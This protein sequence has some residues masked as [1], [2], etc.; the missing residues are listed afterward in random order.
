L[1]KRNY[2]LN[3]PRKKPAVPIKI[4]F[5]LN[6]LQEDR[7]CMGVMGVLA[8]FWSWLT[9]S[10]M[11]KPGK[12]HPDL[13]PIDVDSLAKEL[14]LTV[15]AKRLGEAGLPAKDS[16][17]L[18][19]PEAAVVQRV[20]KARQDYVDWA[21]LR[22]N[23]LNQDLAR[24]N[25]T[26]EV[27]R[28]GQ[29]DKE[30]ERKASALLAE[31]DSLLHALGETAKKGKEELEEFRKRN[32]L[33][34]EA[35]YPTATGTYLRYGFLLV[36]ICFEGVVNA[37]FFAQGLDTGLIGGFMQAAFLAAA[38]VL[39]AFFI[40][41]YAVRYINHC[42]IELKLL[43]FAASITA[44]T[45]MAAMGLGISHY[46]DSLTAEAVDPARAAL[47]GILAN[48]L[49]LKDFF[50][51]TLFAITSAFGIASLFDGLFSDD[52]YPRYGSISRRTYEVIE[53]YEEE[54]NVLRS[55]LEEIKDEVLT[56][57]DKTLQQSQASVAAFESLIND[58]RT[59]GS[60]LSTAL[61]DADHSLEA[62][63]Q[64]FRTE[65]Q[66]YRNG[67]RPDYFDHLPELRP[68]QTPGF[69]TSADESSLAE[70]RALVDNLLAY[71]E[72]IRARVQAAF[73][74]QF[75]RLMPLD[76]HFPGKE[77]K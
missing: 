17:M 41:K 32:G 49:E 47:Q 44:L 76:S 70:Q 9:T 64:K 55:D 37:Q 50:S 65:N 26:Q 63:L 77:I 7:D 48:P 5:G 53:D 72:E 52:L 12:G 35:H 23:V 54:L 20:E 10:R 62:L 43:G 73:N 67:Q 22:Q 21:V 16:K 2:V 56:S 61:R 15:E 42:S 6:K 58:K 34:R 11:R 57:V 71:V 31:Q 30:F 66:I 40:G 19:G 39:I 8:K 29:A 1:H 33:T 25:I 13:Y 3:I 68:I 14:N 28:A 36:L 27:N 24:R 74:Q 18:S 4:R 75:D 45:I 60:R 51:W 69:D 46:R 38:N 59:A